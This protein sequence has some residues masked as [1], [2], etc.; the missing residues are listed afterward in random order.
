LCQ[1]DTQ[2]FNF[3]LGMARIRTIK[4]DHWED[5]RW[6]EVSLQAHLLWIGMKN[7]ADDRGVIKDNAVLIRNK[8]FSSREDIRTNDVIKWL[9]ELVE[10]S[11]LVPL[12]FEGKGY[13][14][15]DF[16]DERIDKPQP[17]SIP[18]SVLKNIKNPDNSFEKIEI[19]DH[20]GTFANVPAG[21]ERKG[22]VEE[23]EKEGNL[24]TR[25]D[26][27]E[28]SILEVFGFTVN[29]NFDKARTVGEFVFSLKN[30]GRLDFFRTQF[31]AYREFKELTNS[32]LHSFSKFLGDQK[33]CFEDGAWNAENWTF[34]LNEEKEKSSAKKEKLFPNG[35]Q[36][37][38]G[39]EAGLAF[40]SVQR[41]QK[42]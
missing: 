34:R 29:Q 32:F 11:F 30:S 4:P 35:Q 42:T 39:I 25:E 15:L 16:S 27:L 2:K 28:D 33:K 37:V 17:S 21:E 26:E 12:K 41:R 1:Y 6:N 3:V 38:R 40:A 10:N 19:P 31:D 24:H 36:T 8:V 9:T 7:F 13:Y 20:S 5:E 18:D 23:G 14:V 22:I